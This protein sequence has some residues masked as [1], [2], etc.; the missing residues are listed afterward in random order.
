MTSSVGIVALRLFGTGLAFLSGSTL[1][2]TDAPRLPDRFRLVRGEVAQVRAVFGRINVLFLKGV[3]M[4][5][6]CS[7]ISAPRV[8]PCW[9]RTAARAPTRPRANGLRPVL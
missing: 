1:I 6:I 9:I 7:G 5:P 2:E 4:A 3:A 8:G